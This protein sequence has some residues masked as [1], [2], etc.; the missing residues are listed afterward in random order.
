[1]N[2]TGHSF[3]GNSRSTE[4]SD[5][6][7]ATNATTGEALE[8]T[9]YSA[10]TDDL[11]KAVSLATVAFQTYSKIEPKTRAKFLRNIAEKINAA[12]PDITPRMM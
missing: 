5:T 4:S 2:L 6:F 10:T 12:G 9:F 7:T 8:P 1:M 3:I 11:E